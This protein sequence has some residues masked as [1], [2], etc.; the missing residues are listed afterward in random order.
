MMEWFGFLKAERVV[1]LS[2]RIV[3]NVSKQVLVFNSF[4]FFRRDQLV[5]ISYGFS[6]RW[7]EM[8]DANPAGTSKGWKSRSSTAGPVGDLGNRSVTP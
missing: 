5:V 3:F 7:E 4:S 6:H 8:D 1:L 2:K